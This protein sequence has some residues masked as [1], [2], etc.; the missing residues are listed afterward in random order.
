MRRAV[1]GSAASAAGIVLLLSLD[2]LRTAGPAVIGSRGIET[3]ETTTG[4]S[5]TA[6]P[7]PGAA[8][9]TGGG[10]RSITGDAVNTRYGPVR[11]RVT[12]S[13]S[14]IT[15]VDVVEYPTDNR[16]DRE[17]NSSALPLLNQEATAAQSA[18]IDVVSGATYTSQ[19]Y[20][21][22]LQSALDRAGR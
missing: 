14:R 4:P 11:V 17:I 22:S 16:R 20:V 15:G 2:S 7:S 6:V 19:G 10:T 8:A 18:A 3:P 9:A 21:R 1:V 13:G 12:L 5:G